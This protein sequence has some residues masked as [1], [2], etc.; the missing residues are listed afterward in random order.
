MIEEVEQEF[1]PIKSLDFY[2]IS[3]TEPWN[4]RRIGKAKCLKYNLNKNGY[5]QIGFSQEGSKS[6]H[7][8]VAEQFI[9]NTDPENK[10][11]VDH[12]DRN[13][14]NN[15]LENLRWVTPSEN[16]KNSVRPKTNPKQQHEYLDDM[17]ENVHQIESYNCFE[18][19]SYYYDFENERLL[20]ITSSNRIKVLKPT[21]KCKRVYMNDVN[22][23]RHMFTYSKLMKFCEELR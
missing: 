9:E 6:V 4:F 1:V 7:R 13:K 14:L 21:Q 2:E 17:P 5:Y 23:K 11:Q 16:I 19:E 15:S 3:T 12:I 18:F 20:M 10:I 8:L 22:G